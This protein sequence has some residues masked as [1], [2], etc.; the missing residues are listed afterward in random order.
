MPEFQNK[1]GPQRVAVIR[2]LVCRVAGDELF[3]ESTAEVAAPRRPRGEKDIPRE[4]A[5]ALVG[6]EPG[7]DR[8]SESVLLLLNDFAR[9]QISEC[10]LEEIPFVEPLQLER[11]G[12]LSR[13]L[14]DRPIEEREAGPDAGQL[15]HLRHLRKVAI[16]ERDLYV[17]LKKAVQVRARRRV[18][19]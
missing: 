14:R 1:E 18:V 17:E 4:F 7:R 8:D 11:H 12:D 16:A 15:G 19:V 9:Q 10:A 3:E 2:G 5:Q 13:D 6:L